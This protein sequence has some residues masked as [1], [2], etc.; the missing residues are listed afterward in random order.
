MDIDELRAKLADAEERNE[1]GAAAYHKLRGDLETA[2]EKL[3]AAEKLQQAT[4]EQ[5]GFR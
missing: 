3:R 2:M 5:V 1:A 4:E